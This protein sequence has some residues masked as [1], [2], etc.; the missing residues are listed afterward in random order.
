MSDRFSRTRVLSLGYG[1][2]GVESLI[3]DLRTMAG[4]IGPRSTVRFH[5]FDEIHLY[6]DEN[7]KLVH[8]EL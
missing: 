7:L 6:M 5:P 8:Y 3:Y 2:C 1:L 4:Y